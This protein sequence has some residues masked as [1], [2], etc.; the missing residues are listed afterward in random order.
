MNDALG[1]TKLALLIDGDNVR[2]TLMPEIMAKAESLG[3]VAVRRI[4]GQF[5]A[6]KMKSWLKHIDPFDLTK[7]DVTPTRSGKNA[8]DIRL[9]IEAMDM[10]H[11]RQLDGV[12]IASSDSDFTQL[13]DR[14]RANAISAYGFGEKKAPAAF[15]K[16]FDR[17]FELGG[18]EAPKTRTRKPPAAK[19]TPPTAKLTPPAAKPAP[20]RPSAGRVARNPAPQKPT[21][22]SSEIFAAID[23]AKG[24]DGWSRLGTVGQ[25]L[26][27]ALPSFT[28][29]KFGYKTMSGLVDAID[30]IEAKKDPNQGA[31][32]RRK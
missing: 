12:C 14:I 16:A 29:K 1:V 7:V 19:P 24:A 23:Q 5:T 10:L 3:T 2:A 11:G 8:A 4:Y 20:A 25:H 13:A 31:F 27:K 26:R 6:G 32:V 15:R 18:A 21:L 17:F 30:G 28:H 9:V 22:P